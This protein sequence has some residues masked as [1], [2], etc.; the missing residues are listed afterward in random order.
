MLAVL[1]MAN[2]WPARES[3]G[4]VL[5]MLIIG[6]LLAVWIFHRHTRVGILLRLTIPALVGV[7]CGWLLMP[8]ID[9]AGFAGVI[10]WLVLG[11]T[12][13]LILQRALPRLILAVEKKRYSWPL[14]LVAGVTTML[15]NAAGPVTTLYFLACR[16]PKMEFVGTAA[17]FY[18]IVN[19]FKVP[20][21]ASLGLITL[22]TLL[23]NLAV[24][25]V[26]VGGVLA[27][28]WLLKRIDQPTF[29]WLMIAFTVVGALRLISAT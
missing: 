12:V 9:S 23:L 17:W 21:S 11:L 24:A 29:E 5:P 22:P 4:A 13:L 18:L 15:A 14:G 8:R 2:A 1:L 16:M 7:V 19:V 28:R 25:P 20:F 6:D 27:A 26:I 10:G 3:T